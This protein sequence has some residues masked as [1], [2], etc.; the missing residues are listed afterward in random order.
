MTYKNP[1]RNGLLIAAIILFL[2]QLSKEWVFALL[3]EHPSSKIEVTS[4]L[5][6]VMVWNRGISFGLFSEAGYGHIVFSI[7]GLVIT[8]ILL[9]WLKNAQNG[10][11]VTALSLV[12]GGAV[13]NIIDRVRLHAVADFLDF[14][15]GGWHWPAFNLADSAICIGVLLLCSENILCA[16]K[17]KESEK[18]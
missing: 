7:L 13:G 16:G 14:Y 3:A 4:F 15:I 12:I 8:A 2:D 11:L 6:L 18:E 1:L 17:Q 5:N 9:I 10:L